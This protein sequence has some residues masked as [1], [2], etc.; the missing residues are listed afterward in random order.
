MRSI[1]IRPHF[2]PNSGYATV[3]LYSMGAPVSVECYTSHSEARAAAEL[4]RIGRDTMDCRVND[5]LP[6]EGSL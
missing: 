4:L 1:I 2:G 6:P 5:K 3:A